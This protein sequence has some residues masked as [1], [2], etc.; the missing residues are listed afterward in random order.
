MD[1]SQVRGLKTFRKQVSDLTAFM[2]S[3]SG[4]IAADAKQVPA[5]F[6]G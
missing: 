1:T 2:K 6:L 3:L 5:A 4:D